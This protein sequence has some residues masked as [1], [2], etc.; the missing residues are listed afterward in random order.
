MISALRQ[1]YAVIVK[2]VVMPTLAG[3]HQ[4]P[5]HKHTANPVCDVSMPDGV[6]RDGPAEEVAAG[7]AGEQARVALHQPAVRCGHPHL[8]Q[9]QSDCTSRRAGSIAHRD[10]AQ[11][12]ARLSACTIG[13]AKYS[14]M[15]GIV[16]LASIER[17]GNRLTLPLAAAARAACVSAAS[18]PSHSVVNSRSSARVSLMLSGA[19]PSDLHEPP[20]AAPFAPR[21]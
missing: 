11:A 3:S 10:S 6:T 16:Y 2:E 14:A 18:W 12:T 7:A 9:R 13:V 19:P 15:M 4:S 21:Q 17:L 1:T 8:R 20:S 5:P